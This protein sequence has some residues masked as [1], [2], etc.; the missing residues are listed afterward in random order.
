LSN[1]AA[2]DRGAC[3]ECTL[4]IMLA[5]SFFYSLSRYLSLS[6]SL[7]FDSLSHLPLKQNSILNLHFDATLNEMCKVE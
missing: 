1:Q 3:F 2:H 6:L 4:S 5:C 7:S